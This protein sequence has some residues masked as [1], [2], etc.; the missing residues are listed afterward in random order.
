MTEAVVNRTVKKIDVIIITA[1]LLVALVWL[2]LLLLP[3]SDGATG[4]YVEIYQDGELIH[5]FDLAD[6]E[7]DIRLE[8]P[9]GYNV[10]RL[11]P[12]G[13]RMLEADCHNQDCVRVGIQSSPGGVIACLPHHLLILISGSKEDTFDAIVR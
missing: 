7:W 8:S 11:G 12:M 9:A 4:L 2:A 5:E 3:K 1:I 10:L 6:E 13:V